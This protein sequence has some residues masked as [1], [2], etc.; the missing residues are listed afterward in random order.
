MADII[1]NLYDE[2]KAYQ[3]LIYQKGRDVPSDEFNEMQDIF[4]VAKRRTFREL[5]GDGFFALG[6][7]VI[8]SGNPNE[9]TIS[10]GRALI[11][12]EFVENE[13]QYNIQGLTTP[14]GA[15]RQDVVYLR[16]QEMEITSADD[17]DIEFADIGETARRI[18]LVIDVLVDEG[19][20]TPPT[21]TGDLHDGGIHYEPIAILDRLDGNANITAAMITDNRR[22]IGVSFLNED[23]NLEIVN[24]GN[25]SWEVV[26]AN[27]VAFDANIRIIQPSTA[28]HAIISALPGGFDL[29]TSGSVAYVNLDRNAGSDYPLSLV[30]GTW[31]TI[32]N[33]SNAFPIFYRS[34]DGRLYGVEGTVWDSGQTHPMR[35]NPFTGLIV[36]ADVSPTADIQGSKLLDASVPNSK[37]AGY[38]F[39]EFPNPLMALSP[40]D[41]CPAGFTKI[42]VGTNDTWLQLAGPAGGATTTPFGS[43]THNH[44]SHTHGSGSYRVIL[45]LFDCDIFD[46]GFGFVFDAFQPGV[47]SGWRNQSFYV[48]GA[49]GSTAISNASHQPKS[50]RLTLCQKNP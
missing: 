39:G 8:E 29:P 42:D 28:G 26:G 49:S 43:N 18:K 46:S 44:G 4:R 38:P 37:L 12:G 48:S 34:D 1:V 32:P 30:Y 6:F 33:N 9:I 11:Q 3:K 35:V 7:Q 47:G 5:W 17:T 31:T 21:T 45:P 22:I 20:G 2:S 15:D 10:A 50:I 16:A 25:V 19:T 14:S 23:K 24:G 40:T 36:D 41:S 13:T 27:K